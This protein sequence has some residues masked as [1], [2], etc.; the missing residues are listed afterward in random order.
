LA[1]R[2]LTAWLG[3]ED[4]NSEMSSQNIPLKVAQ[5]SADQPNSGRTRAAGQGLGRSETTTELPNLLYDDQARADSATGFLR[6]RYYLSFPNLRDSDASTLR[7]SDWEI[8]N[9][10]AIR[11]GVI[12]ALKVAR[13][14]LTWPCVNATL[15]FP[16]CRRSSDSSVVVD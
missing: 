15:G 8:P 9:Y 13:T 11:V 16:G 1:G 6:A 2:N 7:T 4:S 10:L 12:P 5:I 3:W 14:A